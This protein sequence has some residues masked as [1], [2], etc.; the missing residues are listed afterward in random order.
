MLIQPV[1]I[2]YTRLQGLPVSRNDRSLHR[3]DQVQELS[4]RTSRKSS[5]AGVKEVTLAFGAPHP[6][7]EA[8]NRKVVT[9]QAE[10][11][12]RRMLVALNRGLPLPEFETPQAPASA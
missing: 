8:S 4:S 11:Q 1:T 7:T 12:V 5:P 3:L 9:K 10:D 6:L 2:A